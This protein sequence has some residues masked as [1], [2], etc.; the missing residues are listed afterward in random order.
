MLQ[1][2]TEST[3]DRKRQQQDHYRKK[4]KRHSTVIDFIKYKKLKLQNK[5][6]CLLAWCLNAL[7]AQ[8]GYIVP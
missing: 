7:S 5:L 2:I 6:V 3:L 4:W 8:I 1:E